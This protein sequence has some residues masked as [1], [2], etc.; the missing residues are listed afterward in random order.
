MMKTTTDRRGR[1]GLRRALAGVLTLLAIAIAHAGCSGEG[2]LADNGGMSGTGLS[3]GSIDAF[4]SIF[5][6][7]VRWDL[8]R[9]TVEIDGAAAS[10]ADLRL[11]M[12]VRIEGDFDAGEATG[13]ARRVVFERLRAGPIGASPVET[14]PGREKTFPVLGRTVIVD[15]ETTVFAGGLTFATVAEDDVVIVS[16]FEGPT[17]LKA[18]RLTRAGAFPGT[19]EV[20]LRGL[21]TNLVKNPDDSGIFDLGPITVRY[22][23]TTTFSDTTR[24][25][26]AAGDFV[27]I[28]GTL[29]LSGDEVDADEVEREERGLGRT[30]AARVELA[31]IVSACPES[32]DFCLGAVPVD[33]AGATVEPPGYVPMPGDFVEVEGALVAGRLRASEIESESDRRAARD[34]RIEAAVTS[35]DS[36][37]R[38]LDVLGV[39]V[40]ANGRTRIEDASAAGDEDF[41]FDEI[42]AGDFLEIRGIDQGDGSA[43]ALSIRREDATPGDD[44]V[45]LDGPVTAIDPMTPSLTI[46]GQTWRPDAGTAYFDALGMPRSEEQFFRNPGDV[47]VGDVV[48]LKDED[49]GSLSTLDE[50][51]EVEI[52][53]P[54]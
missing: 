6:N 44:D 20:E 27:E 8:S 14:I 1:P 10:E 26:L 51:D 48:S 13:V 41:R 33:A 7:A 54:S 37:A 5:V 19:R 22:T 21:V 34:V 36:G 32:T 50:L 31:G 38:T 4:G 29:R 24:S 18:T 12:V 45:R 49:A 9:A 23:A 42:R 53:D 16:G 46:L 47:R 28:E 52:E 2:G 25:A 30:D 15:A 43:R 40:R 11:G 17:G 3:E 35:I 39:T